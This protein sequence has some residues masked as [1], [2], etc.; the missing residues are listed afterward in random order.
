MALIDKL[1]EIET[2]S[3]EL[4]NL[5]KLLP[6]VENKLWQKYRLEFNYNSNH[7]EG[8]TL[9][10]GQTELLLIFEKTTGDHQIREFEEMKAHDVALKMIVELANDKERDLNEIF[11]KE[12]N[13]CIL[14]R[15]YYK[16]AI[17]ADGQKTRK[18]I[19][20]GEYK[21]LPNHVLLQNGETFYYASP[22]ETPAKMGDL[23]GF[24]KSGA[25]N[26]DTNPVELAAMIHYKF[27]RI[28]PFDDGNGRM[29]RLLMNYILLKNNLPPV[30]IKSADKPKYLT[31]LNKADTG[32]TIAF[33]EYIAEQLI[34]SLQLKIKAAKGE[35]FE[36]ADDYLKEIKLLQQKTQ[37]TDI[38]K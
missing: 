24:Y 14:V 13:Q 8:N 3:K 21:K 33:V 18:E 37:H 17:T 1:D 34:W 12:L 6:E 9:T 4:N 36:E 7:M 35:D 23:M 27:V 38:S 11:I 20:V 15:P 2:L 28:H 19:L 25:I 30:V 22:E 16:D 5:P 29:A 26:F 32:D 31:A 10:Y